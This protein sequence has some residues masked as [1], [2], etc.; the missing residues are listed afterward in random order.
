MRLSPWRSNYPEDKP[1]KVGKGR[2]AVAPTT[3]EGQLRLIFCE[4]LGCDEGQV[5]A[6]A[7]LAELGGDYDDAAE[8]AEAVDELMGVVIDDEYDLE[9]LKT[10]GSWLRLVELTTP[11]RRGRRV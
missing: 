7:T 4:V 10:F 6:T 8:I 1:A 5:T 11:K 3:S 9:S 2:V